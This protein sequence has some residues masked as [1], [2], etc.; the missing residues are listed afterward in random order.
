[1]IRLQDL[2]RE[3]TMGSMAPYTN[4]FVWQQARRGLISA[5]PCDGIPV[6]FSLTENWSVGGTEYAFAIATPSRISHIR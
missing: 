4:Q 6:K 3:I 1:M 5:A 2:L